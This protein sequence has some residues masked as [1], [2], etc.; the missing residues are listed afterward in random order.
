MWEKE[1]LSGSSGV[2][3]NQWEHSR[4]RTQC[5]FRAPALEFNRNITE[6][7]WCFT[8]LSFLVSFLWLLNNKLCATL[9]SFLLAFYLVKSV[10]SCVLIST[11]VSL[12]N[13]F[14][15]AIHRN[16]FYS[17]LSLPSCTEYISASFLFCAPLPSKDFFQTCFL[18]SSSLTAELT[19][20]CLCKESFMWV[21]Q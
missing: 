17:I 19:Y 13:C 3:S 1:L 16:K 20:C 9:H 8:E 5:Q 15:H 14:Q 21:M 7:S 2:S 4:T 10:A 18:P 11:A 6:K 12:C